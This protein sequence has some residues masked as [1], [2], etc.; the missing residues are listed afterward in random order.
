MSNEDKMF[1]LLEKIYGEFTS[2]REETSKELKEIK[3]DVANVKKTVTKIENDHGQKLSSLFDGYKQNS[4]KLD[5]IEQE[6]SKH[7]EVILRRVR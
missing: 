1:N 2:F 3:T 4:D 5:R 6:V 7:E